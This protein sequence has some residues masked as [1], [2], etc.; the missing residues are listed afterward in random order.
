MI[1]E[2]FYLWIFSCFGLVTPLGGGIFVL[3]I[4]NSVMEDCWRAGV[5]NPLAQPTSCWCR[6]WNWFFTFL[7]DAGPSRV[8][9][10]WEGIFVAAF[11]SGCFNSTL[12]KLIIWCDVWFIIGYVCTVRCTLGAR[13]LFSGELGSSSFVRVPAL[14]GLISM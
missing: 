3:F 8:D 11:L 4:R 9:R 12:F 10:R 5:F 13:P 7:V 6:P 1:G 14:S 2:L